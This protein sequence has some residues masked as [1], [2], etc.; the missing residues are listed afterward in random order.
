MLCRTK[1]VFLLPRS[2][3]GGGF[4]YPTVKLPADVRETIALA[5]SAEERENL[6]VALEPATPAVVESPP[7][8]AANK[9]RGLQFR[10]HGNGT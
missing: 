4:E 6:P 3:R 1:L 8:H 2:G 10:M 5:V 7:S 9:Q